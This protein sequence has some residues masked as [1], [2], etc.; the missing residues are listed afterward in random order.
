MFTWKNTT[1]ASASSAVKLS[2]IS[3]EAPLGYKYG[4]K[5]NGVDYPAES[6]GSCTFT[7]PAEDTTVSINTD[8]LTPSTGPL[9]TTA[10]TAR[11]RPS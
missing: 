7:M 8:V 9:R 5:V 4:Y 11:S 1:Y 6:D 10:A 3:P 2:I